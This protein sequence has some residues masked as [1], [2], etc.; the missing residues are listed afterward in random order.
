[1]VEKLLQSLMLL[2]G[3]AAFG[4]LW[5]LGA[6]GDASSSWPS[7][8][9]IVQQSRLEQRQVNAGGDRDNTWEYFPYISYHYQVQGQTY[10]SAN[11]RFPNP[12]Y[13]RSQQ[14]VADILARYPA[15]AQV[16]VYYNPAKPAEACLETGQHWTAWVGKAIALLIVV[17][18]AGLLWRGQS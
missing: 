11:R 12:G 5:W 9:G 18:A 4:Y 13:S 17:V 8:V 3:L 7:A 15:G 1:M 10:Q 6:K 2:A 16:R 14:E